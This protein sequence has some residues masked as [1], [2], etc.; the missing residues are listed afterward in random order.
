MTQRNQKAR[1]LANRPSAPMTQEDKSLARLARFIEERRREIAKIVPKGKNVDQVIKTALIAAMED[2]QIIEKCTPL[3]IYRSVMQAAMMDVSVGRGMNEAYLIRYGNS[4]TLR[5]SYLGL[6]KIA[7]RSPGVDVIRASVVY[8]MDEFDP[9]EQPPSLLHR[10]SYIGDRG[11]R[12]GAVAAAYTLNRAEDG[13]TTHVLVDFAFVSEDELQEAQAQAESKRESPAWRKWPNEMAKKV[14][15]R[16]LVKTLPRTDDLNRVIGIESNADEGVCDVPDPAIDS[17]MDRVVDVAFSEEE[18]QP[19]RQ[20]PRAI[21]RPR[22]PSRAEAALQAQ[23][24]PPEPDLEED[25]SEAEEV[26]HKLEQ[27]PKASE[28]PSTATSRLKGR[29]ANGKS[30]SARGQKPTVQPAVEEEEAPV[31]EEPDYGS[32]EDF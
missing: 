9:S 25:D 14:A 24:E 3:S 7:R 19:V 11:E 13:T 15:V 12:V 17:D 32:E 4:C 6:M 22:A 20:G 29:I 26:P 10:C 1:A 5:V 27:K 30:A 16:R 28:K 21:Q 2:S 8:E 18:P 23:A 31:D